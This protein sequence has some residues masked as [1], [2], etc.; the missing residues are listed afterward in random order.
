[1]LVTICGVRGSTPAPGAEFVRYGGHTSCV[2]LAHDGAPPS[3]ILDSGTG[4][5]R[6]SALLSGEPFLGTILLGHLHWDHI[7]GAPF[8]TSA[9]MPGARV[10]VCMPSQGDPEAIFDGM[11]GHPYFPVTAGELLG[12]WEFT[13]LEVGEHRLEGF[14]VIALEIPHKGGRTFGFRVSDGRSTI[15]YMSDHR[16]TALGQGP[17]GLGEYHPAAL[18]LARATD[19]LIHDAQYTDDELPS[20]E[21]WGH[22]SCGYAVGLAELARANRLLLF[23]HDPSRTDDALD[24]IVAGYRDSAVPVEAASER[25]V[26]ELPA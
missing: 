6:V 18:E 24:R 3:L 8:F 20:K 4:I 15:T 13:A 17:A 19:L 12:D 2:A 23:H 11:M 5:R 1:V 21:S 10:Q 16:P 9:D 14:D 25:M 26:I 22:S 7:M